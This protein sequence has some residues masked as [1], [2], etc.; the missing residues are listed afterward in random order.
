M[1]FADPP[2]LPPPAN[3]AGEHT[4]A[5]NRAAHITDKFFFISLLL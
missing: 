2:S 1:G 5:T 3:S 4:N